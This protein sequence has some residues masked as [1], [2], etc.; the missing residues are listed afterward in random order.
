MPSDPCRA[1]EPI[2]EGSKT[3]TVVVLQTPCSSSIDKKI[4]CAPPL[5]LSGLYYGFSLF[6]PVAMSHAKFLTIERLLGA[7]CY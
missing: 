1:D 2:L 5:D 4:L 3:K 6:L 7:R